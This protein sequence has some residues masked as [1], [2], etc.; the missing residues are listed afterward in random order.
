MWDIW[1]AYRWYL[2]FNLFNC[3]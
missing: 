2:I 3:L 1:K